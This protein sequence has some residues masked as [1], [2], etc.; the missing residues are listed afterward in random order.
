MLDIGDRAYVDLSLNSEDTESLVLG[1]CQFIAKVIIK[2]SS[3]M[4]TVDFVYTLLT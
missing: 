2:T 4:I 3:L 1:D